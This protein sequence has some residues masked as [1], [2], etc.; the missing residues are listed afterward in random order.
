V[1]ALRIVTPEEREIV[2]RRVVSLTRT[3]TARISAAAN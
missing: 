2:I 1:L 3:S